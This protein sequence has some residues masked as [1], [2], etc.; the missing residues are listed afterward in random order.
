VSALGPVL[1]ARQGALPVPGCWD[2]FSAFL[3]EEAGFSAAFL[4]GAALSMARFGLPDMGFVALAE[5]VETVRA[6]RARTSLP[7]IVDADTGF[8][9]ALNAANA[10]RLLEA[11]GASAV[12]IEDQCAPKR[13][14]HMAGKSVIAPAEAAGK[15]RAAV[16]ARR[17]AQTMI[18]ARTDA[19]AIEGADAAMDR[20]DLYLEAGAHAVFIEGPRTMAELE[21]IA[22]RFAGRTP[23]VHNLVEGGVS[24]VWT[25]GALDRLG[26]AIAYHPLLLLNRF[27]RAGAEVLGHLKVARET[28]SLGSAVA[29]LA[30]MNR[31]LGADALIAAGKIYGGD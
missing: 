7:L 2:G 27:R 8:G 26:V 24:P 14:G 23:L 28:Q 21:A 10:V 15:V 12:Q 25:G 18:I 9:N 16:D 29:Y 19:L 4:S 1:A 13:C 3:I 30:E 5:L 20:A 22:S 17:A 11:A 6:I 31:L